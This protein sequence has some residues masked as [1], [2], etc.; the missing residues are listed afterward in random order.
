MSKKVVVSNF[1]DNPFRNK[2]KIND[3]FTMV[4]VNGNNITDNNDMTVAILLL[5]LKNV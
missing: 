3:S 5:V 2:I 1:G 4:I